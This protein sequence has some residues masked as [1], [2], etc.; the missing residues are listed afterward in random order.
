MNRS[1]YLERE[2]RISQRRLGENAQ[3][4]R[5]RLSD[6]SARIAEVSARADA[7]DAALVELAGLVDTALTCI[8][9]QN[10]ALV[11]LAGLIAGG[12]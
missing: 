8:D 5:E 2:L 10:A 9:E 7:G 3:E 6:A 4:A 1:E 11:E 12:E